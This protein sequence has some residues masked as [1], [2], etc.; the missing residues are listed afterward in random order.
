MIEM[1]VVLH[2]I[3]W[4]ADTGT[5]LGDE[6]VKTY[7]KTPG[8]FI[9]QNLIED[10]RTDGIALAQEAVTRWRRAHKPNAFANV[11]CQWEPAGEDA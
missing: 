4:D 3:I 11:D 2:L 10:C 9:P 8:A 1:M 7:R 6:Y 5:Q